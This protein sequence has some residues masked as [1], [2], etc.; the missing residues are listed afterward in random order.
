MTLA[1]TFGVNAETVGRVELGKKPLTRIDDRCNY[2]TI[3]AV[4][5]NARNSVTLLRR[6]GG[7]I[8][9]NSASYA[10]YRARQLQK[11]VKIGIV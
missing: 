3:D 4:R 10:R 11:N 2:S 9:I 7:S 1:S 5:N 8:F 6:P